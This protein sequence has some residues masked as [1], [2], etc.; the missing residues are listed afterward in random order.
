MTEP[1]SPF[2]LADDSVLAV[3]DLSVSFTQQGQVTQAVRQLS[4]EV[5]RG[6]TLALVGE[7]GS[8]K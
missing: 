7:S 4:L 3:R 1:S 5:R 8:G 2:M 6:E